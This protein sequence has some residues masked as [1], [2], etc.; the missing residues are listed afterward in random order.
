MTYNW[1]DITEEKIKNILKKDYIILKNDSGEYTRGARDQY[2][3]VKYLD[4]NKNKNKN[5]NS[6]KYVIKDSKN[7]F[8]AFDH[9]LLNNLKIVF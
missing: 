7:S 6:N 2:I 8:I 9:S 1:L 3:L 4:K 5:K